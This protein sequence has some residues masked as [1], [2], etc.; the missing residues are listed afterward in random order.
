MND[1][2]PVFS[3]QDYTAEI[4]EVSWDQVKKKKRKINTIFNLITAQ[5]LLVH[6]QAIL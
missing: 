4:E 3:K 2:K 6:S 5:P 1:N